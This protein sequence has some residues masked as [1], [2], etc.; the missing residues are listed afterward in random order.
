MCE[1]SVQKLHDRRRLH[2]LSITSCQRTLRRPYARVVATA[3]SSPGLVAL[4]T[5]T[6]ISAMPALLASVAAFRA[7]VPGFFFGL[8]MRETRLRDTHR[9]QSA[10][11]RHATHEV[12]HHCCAG[13]VT[14]SPR[15]AAQ[16]K[17]LS[18][19]L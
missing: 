11:G 12:R 1:S 19:V 16:P 17:P 4:P 10:L 9:Q 2:A 3:F 14:A 18:R 6:V 8:G 7:A 15:C 5:P 13:L